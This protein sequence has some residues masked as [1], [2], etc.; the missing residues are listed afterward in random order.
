MNNQNKKAL[1]ISMLFLVISIFEIYAT[2]QN[3]RLL[4]FIFK[5]L[6]TVSLALLYIVSVKKPSFLFISALFFSFWG[7]VLLL[8]PEKYFV[9]GLVSFLLTH[10]IFI[11]IIRG[12]ISNV[13]SKLFLKSAIFFIAYFGGIVYLIFENLNE[14]LIPVL[15][16][17]L[18]ISTF[19][20]F[21]TVN[22]VKNK[23]TEN[24]WLLVG[25]LIFILSD[26]IIAINKFYMENASLGSLI[27]ITYIVAQYLIC[28]AM[29]AKTMQD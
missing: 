29:I 18:V 2:I 26:S 14:L 17:G 16:Y 8:F 23:A 13:D 10:L 21:A 7:D 1:V 4:E 15:V 25:A 9:L 11:K 6:I 3:S 27:M 12:F 19:G 22:Y 20:T 28:K 24:L 5:P